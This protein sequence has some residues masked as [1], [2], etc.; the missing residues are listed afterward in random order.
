MTLLAEMSPRCTEYKEPT[1]Q[2]TTRQKLSYHNP[3]LFNAESI[4]IYIYIYLRLQKFTWSTGKRL[5]HFSQTSS[6]NPAIHRLECSHRLS[7]PMFPLLQDHF[8][9]KD[10]VIE[11][12]IL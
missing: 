9:E 10:T 12:P 11:Q 7:F 1:N 2:Q 6:I 8:A 5:K 3:I 4:Y